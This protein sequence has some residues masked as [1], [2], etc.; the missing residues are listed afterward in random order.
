LAPAV[1]AQEQVGVEHHAVHPREEVADQRRLADLPR[2]AD[3]DNGKG[4]GH[5][6]QSIT[7]EA[8]AI[9]A[10]NTMT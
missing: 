2:H 5:A 6:S 3:D 8:L 7:E 9:H 1:I 4:F 10:G